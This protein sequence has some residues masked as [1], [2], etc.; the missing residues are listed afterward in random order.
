MQT[1]SLPKHKLI[2][3]K[4]YKE[5]AYLVPRTT[6]HFDIAE[7]CTTVRSRLEVVRNSS[8]LAGTP[9]FL[10]GEDLAC[11]TIKLNHTVLSPQQ[12]ELSAKGLTITDPPAEFELEIET[13]LEVSQNK[14]GEGLYRSKGLYCTQMEA[15]GF[16]RVTYFPDRPDVLSCFTTTIVAERATCPVLLSNGNLIDSGELASGRHFCTWQ[17]PF[18][19]PCYLFA[20]VAGDLGY[21]QDRFVTQSGKTVTL[22]VYVEKGNEPRCAHAMSSLKKAMRWDEQVFGLEYDLDLFMIVAVSDF[23]FGAMENK[24]LNVFNAAYVLADASSASDR[25]FDSIERVV[26]HEY[27]HNW[28]GNRVT[29][30]DWFQLTLKEG[31]TVFR[32]QEFSA[33]MASRAAKRI[34]DA[35]YIKTAQF[36]ED[37][38]PNAHPIRPES[39]I[40]INNFY[41]NTVYSKGAE[42]IRMVETLIGRDNFI[43]GIK[44][45]FE[46]YDGKA[47]TT[48]DFLHAM[49][50]VSGFDFSQFCRWYDQAGTPV[51][52]IK[53]RYLAEQSIYELSVSQTC[54]PTPGQ[55]VKATF[56]FPLSLGLLDSSGRELPLQLEGEP[57]T[58]PGF[59]KILHISQ[60]QQTF[61]FVG[62]KNQPVPSLLRGFSAP[63]K[64]KYDYSEAELGLLLRHDSDAYSRYEAAQNLM[65]KH[66]NMRLEG[67]EAKEGLLHEGTLAELLLQVMEDDT[68]EPAVRSVIAAPPPL[69]AVVELKTPLDHKA[70]R[71]ALDEF[72]KSFSRFGKTRLESI[73]ERIQN[74][75]NKP[76]TFDA[77]SA[78]RRALKNL[79]L[80]L[81]LATQEQDAIDLAYRQ[82]KSNHNMT[83]V[84]A[85]LALLCN[86]ESEEKF[87]ALEAFRKRWQND[88]LVMDKWFALQAAANIPN[89][90]DTVKTLE[91][92]PLFDRFNPNKIRALYSTFTQ[93]LA[94]FHDES[95]AAYAFIADKVI[96]IDEFNNHVAA[97]LAGA[98]TRYKKLMPGHKQKMQSE[99]KRILAAPRISRGVFEIVSK[100]LQDDEPTNVDAQE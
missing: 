26:A 15:E 85:A 69:S 6:L 20:L 58:S 11:G 73:Y 75:L 22:R 68:L 65:F 4:D 13:K 40:E 10:N 12:F 54:P 86:T 87:E 17:D 42:V 2:Y 90:L 45:Y 14:S 39:Y 25:D 55:A 67:V 96:E 91:R 82:F 77:E 83:D 37:S 29:C 1:T 79:A 53:G 51:C 36:L 63:V 66:L 61:R 32:D 57:A 89:V 60:P 34:G 76:Y 35:H 62:I 9:F 30:R 46:L 8:T 72:R 84:G 43:K 52:E 64:L 27:F 95:G 49:A 71:L 21:I 93:N 81:L 41:T 99:L 80:A 100:T 97:R 48:E 7:P 70:S 18:P 98:F 19:K 78:G 88:S 47:V 56:F 31:L 38:G 16:R 92:H 3:L 24:G 59:T 50:I 5:P 74:Q 28:T 94:Y 33:D 23:N 44:K